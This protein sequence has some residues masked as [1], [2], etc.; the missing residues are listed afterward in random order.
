LVFPGYFALGRFL[1]PIP[2]SQR[3]N[4][5]S[6]I[7]DAEGRICAVKSEPVP[8]TYSMTAYVYD[9]DGNRVA[10]GALSSWP[11]DGLCPNLAPGGVFTPTNSYVL[12]PSGEQLTETDGNGNWIH[13]NVFAAGMLISTYDMAPTGAPA[14]NAPAVHFQ[15]ED[16]LGSR[17]VQTDIAGNQEETFSN[18]PFGDGLIANPVSGAPPTADDATEHH[19]TGK[20]RDQESGNDYF[21]ARYYASTMGR[22]LSPDW[23][24]KEE[25]VP[26]AKLDNPQTLNLYQ[27]MRNNPLGGVDPDGHQEGFI[28]TPEGPVPLAFP[29]NGQ[30]TQ[31]DYNRMGNQLANFFAPLPGILKNDITH[32]IE[33]IKSLFNSSGNSSNSPAPATP[34]ATPAPAT[35]TAPTTNTNPYAGPV[36]SPVT[37]V[38][39]KGNAIPVGAGEQLQGSKDGKWTQVKDPNGQPTGTRVDG[40]HPAT[41]HPDPRAQVPHA[42]VPGTTNDDGTP[43]LPVKQ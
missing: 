8:G 3:K 41:S 25:P 42:H 5:N 15:L 37:V 6:Y 24:A 2:P 38:D 1:K 9:A 16:W 33:S 39:P 35:S 13:S 14:V 11:T 31:P 19:F 12:G 28:I 17:R 21:G 36:S 4:V 34:N 30:L 22:F 26:Y 23:S 20:E 40:G 32:P 27:Y 7:Y 18:L 10:K 43:W 29:I